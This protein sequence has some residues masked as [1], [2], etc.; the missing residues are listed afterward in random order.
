[1]LRAQPGTGS[2]A[3]S[4]RKNGWVRMRHP[5][6][7]SSRLPA[8]SLLRPAILARMAGSEAAPLASPKAS[9]A[10]EQGSVVA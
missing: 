8:R 2:H 4:G 6:A 1:M 10:S 3:S 5:I 7:K 9:Q